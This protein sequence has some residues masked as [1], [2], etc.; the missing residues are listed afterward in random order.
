[1][2]DEMEAELAAAIRSDVRTLQFTL[3]TML[4]ELID[5]CLRA[6]HTAVHTEHEGHIGLCGVAQDPLAAYDVSVTEEGVA[7][8]EYLTLLR[9]AAEQTG[10]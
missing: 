6:V 1:M 4:A 8:E 9:S 10:V 7:L 5:M 2:D 3:S